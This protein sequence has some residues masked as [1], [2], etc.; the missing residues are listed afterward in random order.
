MLYSLRSLSVN[1]TKPIEKKLFEIESKILNKVPKLL[2]D[3]IINALRKYK[4]DL[5]KHKKVSYP[6]NNVIKIFT[7]IRKNKKIRARLKLDTF[8]KAQR[9]SM[10]KLF[11]KRLYFEDGI[12]LLEVYDCDSKV[13]RL[14]SAY[15]LNDITY[16]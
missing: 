11:I 2:N 5:N 3:E 14:I 7:A 15:L 9:H 12:P 16:D 8:N 1:V 13:N 4:L 10:R 6:K